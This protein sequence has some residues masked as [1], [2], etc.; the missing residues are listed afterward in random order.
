VV[1]CLLVSIGYANSLWNDFAY[2]DRVIIVLNKSIQSLRNI[3]A[4]LVSDY[5]SNYRMP[6][7]VADPGSSGLYR[8]LVTISYALN[9]AVSGLQA[10]G[11][12]LANL[13]LHVL[14]SWCVYLFGLQLGL[15]VWG[16]VAAAVLFAAHPIH[17]EAVTGIVGRADLLMTLGMLASLWFAGHGRR[18]LSLG[19]FA[20]ALLSK[21]QAVMLPFLL[22]LVDASFNPALSLPRNLTGW[23]SLTAT[24]L[25]RYGVYLVLLAGYLLAR[26]AIL[27]GVALPPA[28]FL[29]NP[30]AHAD[31]P[32][33]VLTALKVAG[34]YVWLCIW[35]ALLSADYSYNAIHLSRSFFEPDVLLASAL[36]GGLLLVAGLSLRGDRRASVCVG[37]T[38]LTF[39]PVSNL[40]VPTGTIMGERLFYLPSVGLCL[41]AGLAADS[42]VQAG[43]SR[44]ALPGAA[45][46]VVIACIALTAR[47]A[48]RNQD[49]ANSETLFRSV[50]RV[51]P[52]NAKGHA[53]LG[54]VLAARGQ[55][56][57]AAQEYER[58]LT[59]Y[60]DYP[61][62][63][64]WFNSTY[65]KV[66]LKAGK[67]A[68]ATARAEE[69]VR[70]DGHWSSSHYNAGLVYM[71]G[72]RYVEAEW[73]FRRAISL[74]PDSHEPYLGLSTV[75][76][77]QQRFAEALAAAESAIRR[78]PEDPLAYQVKGGALDGLGRLQEAAATYEAALAIDPSLGAVR[79]RLDE[80]RHQLGGMPGSRAEPSQPK[81][82]PS[83]FSLC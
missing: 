58:A 38:V 54:A 37:L 78:K 16:A 59:I 39:L 5:W 71:K 50:I 30:L 4:L 2:D 43:R 9:Y 28:A 12:H 74:S 56:E 77:R 63:D 65:L 19:A 22:M 47:T 23:L 73:A 62:A 33:W 14:V 55:W 15:S 81:T 6:Q 25:R 11:Y 31:W 82:C 42:F 7:G 68:D 49:W 64:T 75:L 35:P 34:H 52:E 60:P 79:E 70:M 46:L 76:A 72:Q 40:L 20:L 32:M 1:L 18:A 48:I 67:I 29:A 8:P 80:L 51:F 3:P 45:A 44:A 36:W 26:I 66:L 17:A 83:G 27:G 24:G 57:E 53:D 41:L 69:A 10:M 61:R 13:V 21:E